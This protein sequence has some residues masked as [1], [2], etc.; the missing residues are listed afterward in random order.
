MTTKLSFLPVLTICA[1]LLSGCAGNQTQ[2][3][4][5]ADFYGVPKPGQVFVGQFAFAANDPNP[6]QTILKRMNNQFVPVTPQTPEDQAGQAVAQTMQDALM[7]DLTHEG[8]PAIPTLNNVV[9]QV[10]SLIIEGELLTVKSTGGVQ[11]LSPGLATGQT[12]VVSYVNVY[13]VTTKGATSFAKFYSDTRHTVHPEVSTTLD[14]GSAA[15]GVAGSVNTRADTLTARGQSAQADAK[16]IAK[17]IA[18]EMGKLFKAESWS[19]VNSPN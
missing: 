6:D 11:R 13:L 16:L 5:Q 3:M 10:G 4:Q 17:Q 15:S 12:K 19:S 1:V 2:I 9:P 7:K 14:L 8:I 18:K